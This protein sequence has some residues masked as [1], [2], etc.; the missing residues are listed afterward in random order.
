MFQINKYD[1]LFIDRYEG[2]V[3]LALGYKGRDGKMYP[4]KIRQEFGKG[5]WNDSWF[6]IKFE[7]DEQIREFAEW[8]L[9]EVGDS[10]PDKEM[11]EEGIP[12]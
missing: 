3:S 11:T 9:L 10:E 4:R 2:K 12:F 5:N 1:S 6:K 8:L 7:N